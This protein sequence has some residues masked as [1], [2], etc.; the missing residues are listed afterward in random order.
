MTRRQAREEAFILIFEKVFNSDG[1]DEIY[2]VVKTS[3][4]VSNVVLGAVIGC[5]IAVGIAFLMEL[6]DNTVK[7]REEFEELTDTSVLSLIDKQ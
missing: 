7:D 4:I 6:L 3:N 2:S 5:V 1:V